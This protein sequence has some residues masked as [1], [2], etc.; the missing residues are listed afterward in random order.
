MKFLPLRLL[1]RFYLLRPWLHRILPF[2]PQ[3]DSTVGGWVM[4]F[5]DYVSVGQLLQDAL[6][7]VLQELVAWVH[8]QEAAGVVDHCVEVEELA[9]RVGAAAVVGGRRQTADGVCVA[10]VAGVSTSHLPTTSCHADLRAVADHSLI[11]TMGCRGAR[12]S[13]LVPFRRPTGH[14]G[15]RDDLLLRDSDPGDRLQLF[16]ILTLALLLSDSGKL[17]C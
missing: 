4:A 9:V 10:T 6:A 3:R 15:C 16:L 8:L 17:G 7:A 11:I 5:A 13:F 12:T 2:R 14:R 1:L